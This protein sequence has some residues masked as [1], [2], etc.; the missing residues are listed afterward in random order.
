[1]EESRTLLLVCL[2]VALAA[3]VLVPLL[4]VLIVLAREVVRRIRN[5]KRV[6]WVEVPGIGVLPV[7]KTGC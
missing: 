6:R 1:M 4:A 3:L 5:R 7:L 2:N